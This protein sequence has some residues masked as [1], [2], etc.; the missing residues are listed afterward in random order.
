MCS[1]NRDIAAS[2]SEQCSDINSV[3]LEVIELSLVLWMTA[4]GVLLAIK[5]SA[6]PVKIFIASRRQL[7]LSTT[8]LNYIN[9]PTD[10]Y[11]PFP[12]LKILSHFC[13]KIKLR[14]TPGDN[15]KVHV[16]NIW[17]RIFRSVSILS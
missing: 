13:I 1:S 15:T 4:R 10:N 11:D 14:E 5:N 7:L 12:V 6:R 16:R 17:K 3:T 8:V 2:R 9:L